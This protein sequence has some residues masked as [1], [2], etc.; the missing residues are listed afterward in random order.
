MIMLPWYTVY[1]MVGLEWRNTC[2]D[3]MHLGESYMPIWRVCLYST[4][5]QETKNIRFKR[6]ESPELEMRNFNVH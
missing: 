4:K 2:M 1:I 3:F 6:A 5:Q